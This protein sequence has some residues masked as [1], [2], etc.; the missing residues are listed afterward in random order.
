[1][2]NE[3]E[4]ITK[5]YVVEVYAI[6]CESSIFQHDYLYMSCGVSMWSRSLLAIV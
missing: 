4:G 6:I 5:V 3:V 1:M 2:V